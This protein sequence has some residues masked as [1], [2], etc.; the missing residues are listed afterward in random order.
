[1]CLFSE[2]SNPSSQKLFAH[3]SSLSF[4]QK[5]SAISTQVFWLGFRVS[6]PSPNSFNLSNCWLCPFWQYFHSMVIHLWTSRSAS[7]LS[8]VLFS[9]SAFLRDC[10]PSISISDGQNLAPYWSFMGFLS[11]SYGP[12]SNIHC[13]IP[14]HRAGNQT[15]PCSV[16]ASYPQHIPSSLT[17]KSIP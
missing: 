11:L 14:T 15:N 2:V 17:S 5:P 3:S 8:L 12:V 16:P 4:Q 1:M 6:A 10:F 7:G 13:S 9:A